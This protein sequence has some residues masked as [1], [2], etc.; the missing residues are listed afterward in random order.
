[1]ESTVMMRGT[2]FVHPFLYY[3]QLHG[4]FLLFRN[5]QVMELLEEFL[6]AMPRHFSFWTTSG[7]I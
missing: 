5:G 7:T 2:Y 3:C 1:M 4:I 6:I